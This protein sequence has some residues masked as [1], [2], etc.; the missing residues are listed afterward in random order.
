MLDR[1]GVRFFPV[2]HGSAD[3][4]AMA[5]GA[6]LERRWGCV[7]VAL[8][9]SF[10]E[11]VEAAIELLPTAHAV[12]VEEP[13]ELELRL[14]EGGGP[15]RGGALSFVPVEPCQP[16][17][18]ALRTAR[19]ERIPRAFVD[20]E[21]RAFQSLPG[22]YPDAYALKRGVPVNLFAAAILPSLPPPPTSQA[23]ERAAYMAARLRELEANHGSV[24]FLCSL[25]EWPWVRQALHEGWPEPEPDVH[26]APVRRL[27]IREKTLSFV[28]GELPYVAHLYQQRR[29]ALGPT[30]TSAWTGSRSS[31]SRRATAG[32]RATAASS[33]ASRRSASRCCSSTCAT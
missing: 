10:Q 30:S 23:R 15:E 29:A 31:C 20:L 21:L 8:P 18:A 16:V 28:M 4:A 6:V 24:L 32:S 17:I 9:A 33:A 22:L 12:Y 14:S 3:H 2:V 5:S 13:R 25:L 19:Q 7:A 11:E 1:G 27:K 26:Y